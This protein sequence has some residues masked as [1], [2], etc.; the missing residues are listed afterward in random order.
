MG[1]KSLKEYEEEKRRRVLHTIRSSLRGIEEHRNHNT[2]RQWN[3]V[4]R[5]L[6]RIAT[7]T[8]TTTTINSSAFGDWLPQTSVEIPVVCTNMHIVPSSPHPSIELSRA[9]VNAIQLNEA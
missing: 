3:V 8:T 6:A 9:T 1:K 4:P 5:F 2:D 7:T